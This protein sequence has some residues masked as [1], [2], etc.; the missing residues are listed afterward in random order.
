[1]DE[2]D[3][4]KL[5]LL[6]KNLNQDEYP[7]E[8]VE[9]A[10]FA[11]SKLVANP[12]LDYHSYRLVFEL[13]KQLHTEI[14]AIENFPDCV[15]ETAS[16][17]IEKKREG[18][19][20]EPLLKLLE[21]ARVVSR[22]VRN[23]W[24]GGGYVWLENGMRIKENIFGVCEKYLDNLGFK[25]FQIPSEL[26][27]EVID[28]VNEGVV[29]LEKGTY[30]LAEMIDGELQDTGLYANSSNDAVVSYYLANAARAHV[31]VLP[32]KGYSRHQIIRIHRE[33]TVTKPF[34]NSDENYEC[35]EAYSV[36][37]TSEKCEEEFQLIVSAMQ[38]YFTQMGI[39]YLTVDQSNWGNKPV[40]R[41]V[42]SLQTYAAPVN[43]S[44]RLATIYKHGNTFSKLFDLST[45]NPDGS[46]EY[47]HQVGF[48]LWE[49][50][51]IPLF[52]HL[53]DEH[54]LCLPPKLAASHLVFILRDEDEE[55]KARKIAKT[56]GDIR[57]DFD[58]SYKK[59]FIKRL[60]KQRRAGT[61]L[62]VT[63]N[64]DDDQ[65]LLSRRDTLQTFTL[66]PNE[67]ETT[68]PHIFT[69][70]E[71]NY[72]SRSAQYLLDHVAKAHHNGEIEALIRKQNLVVFNHC[73]TETCGKEMEQ[74]MKGEFL[75]HVR[76]L[77]AEGS[78]INCGETAI[79]TGLF[80]RRAPTP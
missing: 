3:K 21:E 75:G 79:K 8:A 25:P 43:G 78:C 34:V 7:A 48:G 19:K 9:E 45:S 65:L 66:N 74:K 28:A 53:S 42:T 70:M 32:F 69:S 33:S 47:A 2:R 59:K 64:E 71:E 16:P 57:I 56:L 49:G 54:G 26:P 62:L 17:L 20:Y 29:N 11:L 35:F 76:E 12:E 50:L 63:L 40:A 1:M 23:I 67:L 10:L 44:V 18:I 60:N 58:T 68:L 22:G 46:R 80:G 37:E 39:S 36:Q 30:W 14:S 24:H 5:F 6:E 73:D 51:M 52:D 38:E 72:S 31:K 15:L 4:R 61:P 77:P 41:K 27:R 13:V 55:E